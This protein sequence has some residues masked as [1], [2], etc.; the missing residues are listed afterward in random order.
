MRRSVPI[1]LGAC[2]LLTAACNDKTNHAAPAPSPSYVAPSVVPL[3]TCAPLKPTAYRWPRQI[4]QD[5]PRIPGAVIESSKPTS[6]GLFIVQ[7]STHTSLR[8]GVLF[9]VKKLPA[10]GYQL[11]RG[12]AEQTEADAPF[13]KGDVRGVLR[14]AA[15]GVCDT[16]WVLAVARSTRTSPLLPMH[17]GPSPSPLP[18]G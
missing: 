17:T 4:P 14:G 9:I 12:D 8:D 3:P 18:F 7:F 13:N 2:L 16:K 10:A 5:L 11:G 6:D 1:L 15:I